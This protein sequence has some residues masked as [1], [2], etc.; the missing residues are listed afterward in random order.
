MI[1]GSVPN[2]S[3]K[4]LQNVYTGSGAH[5]ALFSGSSCGIKQPVHE[6]DH[7][8]LYEVLR[9]RTGGAKPPPLLY[10]CVA[11]VATAL[12]SLPVTYKSRLLPLHQTVPCK[13]NQ[14]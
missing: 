8:H 7:A 4:V 1:W 14:E 10:A 13:C 6:V 5:S 12:L 2:R 11:Y 9:L 3:K